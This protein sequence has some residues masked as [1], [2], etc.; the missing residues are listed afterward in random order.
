ML[1][2]G[3]EPAETIA[4]ADGE[5]IAYYID[6]EA[7]ASERP[8]E[9][10][11][12]G[13]FS[14]DMT[15]S[16]ASTIADWGR[17]RGRRVVRFD[18]FGHGQSSGEFREGTIGRWKEDAL[19]VQE[20]FLQGRHILV[21]SSMG[22]WISL[23][24]AL[25]HPEKVAGLLLLAPAPDFTERLLWNEFS[26]EEKRQCKEQGFLQL[27]DPESSDPEGDAEY[28]VTWKQIEEARNHLLPSGMLPVSCPVR[29]I[30]GMEDDVV[31]WQHSLELIERLET[32]DSALTLVRDSDHRLSEPS[33][34]SR[35]QETL[36]ELLQATG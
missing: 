28:V 9:V 22:G 35:I 13:G 34:L 23:M 3:V 27:G 20:K 16:K 30:H 26:P 25:Q 2:P 11:W 31:P 6:G 36:E 15:G 19:F 8:A 29:I 32:R 33:D 21:G 4:R 7:K 1:E 12:C 10:L 18:Y 17:E 24:L 5:R 14:S